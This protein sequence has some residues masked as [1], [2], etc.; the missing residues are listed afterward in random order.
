M[1]KQI[2]FSSIIV[3]SLVLVAPKVIAQDTGHSKLADSASWPAIYRD[4]FQVERIAPVSFTRN[5]DSSYLADFGRAAFATLE[6]HYRTHKKRTLIIRLGEKLEDRKIDR[7]PG[8][9]IRYQELKLK[10]SPEKE[11]YQLELK[12]DKR[13]TLPTA[14]ALPDT[15]PVLMPFRW[16]EVL[17]A[18]GLEA[19]DLTQLAHFGQFNDTASFFTSSNEILNQVWELCWYSIKATTFCG[20]YVDGDRERIPYEADAYL[21]QLSH[22]AVDSEYSIARRT[23]EYFMQY[24]TWPT[25]WQLHVALLFWQDYMYTGNTD[26]IEKHYE[27]LKHKTLVALAGEDGLISTASPAHDGRLMEALSFEDTTN[28]LRDI[29]DWPQ[30][31]GF[32]G[33]MGETDGFVFRPVNT[34]VNSFYYQN[35]VIM[36]EF[37][38]LLG[39]DDEAMEFQS[40][41]SQV[42]ASINNLLFDRER[43]YYL[44]G[45]GTDHGSVHASML[46]LAMDI[47]PNARKKDVATHIKSRGMAC[48]VYGA[49][50]LL[51]ALYNADESDYALELMTAT[52][53]R[54]WYNM[55][56]S[57]STITMEAWDMKYKPNADWNHAWGAVPA[58]I[59]ARHLWGIRPL[60]P[61]FEKVIIQP[62]PGTL[63]HSTIEVPTIKGKIIA[64]FERSCPHLSRY[65]I[66][67]PANMV[68]VFKVEAGSETMVVFNGEDVLM[69]NGTLEMY[70]GL[71]VVEINH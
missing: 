7:G 38:C 1:L 58:N 41:A 16:V 24:P 10:V 39:K 29:V 48:S 67:L 8:G 25:E 66:V 22:Y 15:F 54:S 21:N 43:G 65:S 53:D 2:S 34:V 13:N 18:K 50:Y 26:L 12:A 55:I 63:E 32:G 60:L 27:I 57:G 70:P 9:N 44:D 31:G 59:I 62:Q 45:L 23:I 3:F 56:R 4:Y 33:V 61:G 51:E 17:G 37:A 36:A 49:Q 35:M 42:K 14:I 71:N 11:S 40:R 47:V 5:R 64:R 20:Y 69:P 30:S 52:H 19:G 6:L 46:P 28:R 68:G